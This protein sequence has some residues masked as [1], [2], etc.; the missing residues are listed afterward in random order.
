MALLLFSRSGAVKEKWSAVLKDRWR[1]HQAS[2]CQE[3]LI[4]LKR[5]PITTLLL[6]HQGLNGEELSEIC[7]Q[8]GQIRI[9]VF[10]DRPDD[11]QGL[12]CLQLGCVGYAH[13]YLAPSRLIA[14]LEAVE[15]GL[16]WVGSSLMQ[17]LIKGLA[18]K[19]GPPQ[20]EQ[21]RKKTLPRLADLSS[22][23]EQIATLVGEGLTNQ[24]IADRFAITERTVKSHLSSIY[25]K[26]G[27]KGRLSLALVV[28]ES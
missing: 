15:S 3:L 20:H 27:C 5:L 6:H 19:E 4:L 14:A 28:K 21:L 25:A 17:Y 13:T 16:A 12:A 7:R 18:A 11:R 2:T 24:E 10:S 9:F 26:T 23:E 8:R 1:I 22:R